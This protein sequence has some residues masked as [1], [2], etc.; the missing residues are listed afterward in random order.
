ML[1]YNERMC[2]WVRVRVR[3]RVCEVVSEDNKNG[4]EKKVERGI[5]VGE[6]W[7]VVI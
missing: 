7:C 4:R 6:F 1:K 3:V 2:M 5:H